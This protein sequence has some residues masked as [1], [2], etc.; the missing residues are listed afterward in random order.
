M[1][2]TDSHCHLEFEQFDHDRQK[3]IR[4]I[5][6]NLEFAVLAGCN[7]K[8]NKKAVEV[9]NQSESLKYCLGL[10]PLYSKNEKTQ[11]IQNQIENN[12]PVAVGEIGLDYNYITSSSERE[13][14][15]K[16]FRKM[17]EIAEEQELAQLSI[18]VMLNGR[19]LR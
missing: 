2:P 1:R 9:A 12:D 7:K 19:P 3:I 18:H 8:D 17:L 16:V 13:R 4:Q 5:E 6:E 15:E 14:S 10:H 11:E